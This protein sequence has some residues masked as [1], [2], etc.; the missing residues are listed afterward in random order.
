MELPGSSGTLLGGASQTKRGFYNRAFVIQ[1]KM[2]LASIA[3]QEVS[4]YEFLERKYKYCYGTI[5][6]RVSCYKK[7]KD[8][9]LF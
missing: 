5:E 9:L 6:I 3:H 7:Y 8:W 1:D 4:L 2:G